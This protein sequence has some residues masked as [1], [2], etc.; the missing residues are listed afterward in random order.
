M[1]ALASLITARMK[2]CFKCNRIL[3]VDDFYKH[4]QMADG[5]LNKCKTCTRK[6]TAERV[7]RKSATDLNWVLAE[8]ERHRLK[9]IRQRL[10]G[11]SKRKPEA[12]KKYR[13]RNPLKWAAHCIVNNAIRDGKMSRGMCEICGQKAHA[14]HDDYFKPLEVRWLCV[15]H[16]AEHHRKQ[17]EA[18]II[19]QFSCHS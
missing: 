13:K 7:A 18:T 5:H 12:T 16:H 10:A 9:A 2:T 1:D 17:R 4:P 14:H 11:A 6:D 15:T 3:P 19:S 8:R